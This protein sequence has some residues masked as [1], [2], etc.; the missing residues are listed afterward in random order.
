MKIAKRNRSLIYAWGAFATVALAFYVGVEVLHRRSPESNQCYQ[1]RILISSDMNIPEEKPEV[2]SAKPTQPKKNMEF[3]L[4]ENTKFGTLPRISPDGMRVLDAYAAHS[5]IASS[6]KKIRT[7]I[8]LEDEKYDD[9][10]VY[11]DKLKNFKVSF[12]VP[13][14]L[15]NLSKIV[16]LIRNRGHEIFIQ[17][18][19]QT[20]IPAT[21]KST[22]SPFLANTTPEDILTKLDYLLAST[23]YVIGIANTS[24]TLLTKS[25]K[26]ISVI[27]DEL[28][29]RGLAFMT[30]EKMEDEIVLPN[31]GATCFSDFVQFDKS[32]NVANLADSGGVL[33]PLK[34]LD[35]FLASVN[36]TAVV[37]I[38]DG[39]NNASI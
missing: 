11:L 7:A 30:V 31:H 23:K 9:L 26:D 27:L 24:P 10:P 12:V 6:A 14:Y 2:T 28:S 32:V 21:R 25:K 19:T 8:V 1:Y 13:H 29:K 5:E 16:S 3:E 38:S 36:E 39:E 37:A 35:D 34:M 18:P 33:V 15:E 20:S 22:V 4:Y 17:L